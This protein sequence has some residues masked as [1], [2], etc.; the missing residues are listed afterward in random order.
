MDTSKIELVDSKILERHVSFDTTPVIVPPSTQITI[1]SSVP[2]IIVEQN[3]AQ[4]AFYSY[5]PSL[6]YSSESLYFT[7]FVIIICVVLY[8]SASSRR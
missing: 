2:P 8:Y 5:V 3:T 4:S 7:T 6:P 1:E